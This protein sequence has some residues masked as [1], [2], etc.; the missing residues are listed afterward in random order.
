MPSD[1]S[2]T[3]SSHKNSK[4]GDKD[5]IVIADFVNTT[6]DTVFDGTLKQALAIQLEQSPFLNVLSDRR[7]SAT[8]K[9]MNKPA[10][11]R[12]THEIAREVCLRSNSKALLEGSIGSVGTHYLIGLKAVNCQT[13]D[14]LAS[15]QA[16]AANRD[17]VLKRLGEVGDELRE[18]LGESLISVKRFNK[19]LD[20]V[21]TSSL[22]ALQ[23]YSIGHSMQTLKGDGES[24]PYHKR[25]IELDPNFARAYASLGMAQY[26]LRETSA[27]A[28]RFTQG[29]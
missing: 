17:N 6:G 8:L 24:V 27:A 25:A 22:E 29:L 2:S 12:L 23:A 19:P 21:T 10:D 16:E 7:V 20:Q 14:N 4:L 13:G 11:A 3:S 28:E 18:K 9:M 26:N 1:I 5:T 15:A